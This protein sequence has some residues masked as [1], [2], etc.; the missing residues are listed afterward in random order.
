VR[1]ILTWIWI[2]D[3]EQLKYS[4]LGAFQKAEYP[5]ALKGGSMQMKHDM[6][7]TDLMGDAKGAAGQRWGQKVIRIALASRFTWGKNTLRSTMRY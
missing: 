5:A 1:T 3:E 6:M 4:Y 7:G 2:C